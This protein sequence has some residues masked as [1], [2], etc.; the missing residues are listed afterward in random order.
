MSVSYTLTEWVLF[1]LLIAAMLAADLGIARRQIKT[2]TVKQSLLWSACWI[3]PAL[4][5]NIYIYFR[6][7]PTDAANFLSGYLIEYNLSVDNLFVFLMIFS[8]FRVPEAYTHKVLFYGIV[9][10]IAMRAFFIFLGIYLVQK[11]HWILYLFGLFLIYSAVELYRR[12]GQKID[13]EQNPLM[14]LIR[15][16]IP[17]T[18][19]YS[20]DSFFVKQGSSYLATPLFAVLLMIE[21]ADFIFAIDSIPA[22]MGI[23]LN[24]FIIY[25]SNILALLGLRSLYFVLSH[26]LTLFHYLDIG[27]A[28]VLGGIGAKLLLSHWIEIPT[29]ITLVFV[30][31]VLG[32]SIAYSL[33]RK[34]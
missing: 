28:I 7:G 19:D 16:Y 31:L 22:V 15:K 13:I 25:T 33:L 24:P 34:K 26:S 12:K 23:T 3:V 17:M 5:F 1:N 32:S 20:G 2:P 18:K 14:Q 8:Y 10:A 30:I 6:G 27:L 11:F 9:G 4:L 29:W 21:S